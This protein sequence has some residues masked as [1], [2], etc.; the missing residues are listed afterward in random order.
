MPKSY[1]PVGG[2]F[3]T[4]ILHNATNNSLLNNILCGFPLPH[5]I[6]LINK[7]DCIVTHAEAN[8]TLCS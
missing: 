4:N 5:N 2:A 3:F 1:A 8:M 6:Q 7:L